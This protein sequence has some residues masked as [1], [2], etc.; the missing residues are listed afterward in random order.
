MS[1]II[2]YEDILYQEFLP[3]PIASNRWYPAGYAYLVTEAQ[4][5]ECRLVLEEYACKASMGRMNAWRVLGPLQHLA[6]HSMGHPHRCPWQRLSRGPWK[7]VA[8]VAATEESRVGFCLIWDQHQRNT[9]FSGST[10][11]RCTNCRSVSP[12]CRNKWAAQSWRTAFPLLFVRL[13]FHLHSRVCTHGRLRSNMSTKRWWSKTWLVSTCWKKAHQTTNW[14]TE[15]VVAFLSL[16][17][18]A[19]IQNHPLYSIWWCMLVP[20]C[21]EIPLVFSIWPGCPYLNSLA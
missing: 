1:H 7:A 10:T 12:S 9:K 5:Q 14:F 4:V 16:Q 21:F 15:H 20:W 13:C 3:N 6:T 11:T 17:C 18:A 19:Q 8:I 2:D